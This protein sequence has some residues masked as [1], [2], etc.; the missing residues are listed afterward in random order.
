MSRTVVA[1]VLAV[2]VVGASAEGSTPSLR[3]PDCAVTVD[4]PTLPNGT[5]GSVYNQTFTG[6]GGIAPYTFAVTLGS[7]P[8]GLTLSSAGV[9]SGTPTLAGSYDFD[10][11][12]TDAVACFGGRSYTLVIDT[13]SC[14]TITISPS[15]VP[16]GQVGVAYNQTLTASGGSG[17]YTYSLLTGVLPAGLSL[18]AGGVISGTPTQQETQAFTVVAT[19]S[20]ACTGSQAYS[21]SITSGGCPMITLTP[22]SLPVGQVGA[23]YSQTITGSGGTAPYSY[24]VTAGSLPPGL[25]L[26]SSG[27]LSGTPTS[28]GTFGFTV[29]ATDFVGCQGSL[30]YQLVINP[31]SCG[32]IALSPSTLPNGQ[33]GVAYG[34]TMTASGG[35]SPYTFAVTSGA[36][37]AGLTLS[38]AGAISGTPTTAGVS[39]FTVTATDS[40]GCIGSQPYVINVSTGG[41][42]GL[43]LLP[44]C[45]LRPS[46]GAPYSFALTATGG[47]TP[48]TFA[49]IAGAPPAGLVLSST[50]VLSGTST[51]TGSFALTVEVT[52]GSACTAQQA[53][54]L[55]AGD[56]VDYLVGE[57]LGATN[58][59][60]VRIY[61]GSGTATSV[62]FQAYGASGWGTNVASADVDTLGKDE[63]LTGPGP[64]DVYGPHVRGFKSD[65]TAI[66]KV[67]FF[68]YST[69]KFGANVG[70]G[71]IDGDDYDEILSG[72]GPGAVFG[73]HVRGWNH[74]GVALTAIAKINFFAYSTLRYGVNVVAALV[75]GDCFAEL[76]T[77]PGPGVV[78]GPQVRGFNYDGAS[79][80]AMAK[81]NFNAY[82]QPMY[83]VNIAAGDVEADRFDELAT[84][85]GPGPGFTS[86]FL[87]FDYDGTSIA[88]AP[89]FDVTT[90][91]TTS[92]GGRVGLG[93]VSRD[94]GADLLAGGGRDP[95]ADATVET[96]TYDGTA[97][98]QSS[99]TFIPFGGFY[100]VNPASGGFGF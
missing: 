57:G 69:L 40:V 66:A 95:G 14:P 12:A 21:L 99:V 62:A 36:L 53:Y 17:P 15:S 8:P 60:Q 76:V 2:L 96:Y 77:G 1:C 22:A 87:G 9:L 52:D 100:G 18:S 26:S 50:G 97:L 32:T 39:S 34:Q 94:G 91:T 63:I 82:S 70:S 49:V 51:A 29:T 74:D 27:G 67:N 35:T 93:D 83:G 30:A 43:A 56:L 73:P 72:A 98:T 13:S 68:A 45:T 19:D 71:S 84:A 41:C 25:S 92:Y 75:D 59:N 4:P 6:S 58:S 85:P 78:F 46:A 33:V 31:A 10:I 7:L 20:L 38:T 54:A 16:S 79:L 48:Y 28:A 55:V 23:S 86:R 11:I 65:G 3:V 5:V 64:G 47:T 80:S 37:P 24:A 61:D 81:I 90:F 42:G 44:E 88:A 89:G